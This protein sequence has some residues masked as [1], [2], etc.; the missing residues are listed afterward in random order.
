MRIY[1]AGDL[2][3]PSDW[4]PQEY[5]VR[6]GQVANAV[7][8]AFGNLL[9]NG[10]G[11]TEADQF[12]R[13]NPAL[14]GQCLNFTNFGHHGMW[15]LPQKLIDPGA[16]RKRRGLKPDYVFGGKSSDGFFWCVAEL[17]GPQD[18]IFKRSGAEGRTISLSSVVNE[19]VCQLLQY[20]EYCSAQQ[21]YIRDHFGLPSFRE[22]IGFLVVG[23]DAEME[24]EQLQELKSAWNKMAGGRIQIRTYDALLRSTSSSWT[25]EEQA[26]SG[27]KRSP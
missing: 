16:S 21:A 12:I 4:P 27:A 1:K 20:I 3:Y 13:S 19:G 14:L 22:P 7:S 6:P 24:D 18:K 26:F 17:K 8:E 25:S 15:V 5:F 10:A 11:E 23:R 9:R 2:P